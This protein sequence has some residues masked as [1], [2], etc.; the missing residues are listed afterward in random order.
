MVVFSP[1]VGSAVGAHMRAKGRKSTQ[2][3]RLLAS[4]VAVANR[5]GYARANVSA[6]IAEAGVSRPTFYDYFNDKDDCF[7]A[8]LRDVQELVAVRVDEVLAA[9]EPAEALAG[10][11]AA[12]ADLAAT[13]P[14]RARFLMSEAMAAGPAALQ[15]RDEGIEQLGRAVDD[16]VAAAAPEAQVPDVCP[17]SVIGGTYRL[18]ASRLRRGEPGIATLGVELE[19]WVASYAVAHREHRWRGL[20]AARGVVSGDWQEREPA[21]IG[22]PAADRPQSSEQVAEN[23]RQRILYAVA[24]LAKEKGYNATT[25]ADIARVA[26]VDAR[27][28]YALYSDKQDAFM[29]VHELGVQQVMSATAEGFFTGTSWAERVWTGGLAFTVF[30]QCN[31]LITQVGFVEA[32]A[33]G[34]RAVQRV[35]DSHVTFTIFL[36]EGYQHDAAT[37][38]PSRLALEAI[39]TTVF[40][41]VYRRARKQGQ[42]QTSGMP[43]QIAFLSLAP[44]AGPAEANAFIGTQLAAVA[45]HR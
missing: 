31:P 11:L 34:P 12:L 40:E 19:A 30:L 25:V 38:G 43:A 33:V 45:E 9:R 21:P 42:L 23:Q 3:E 10:T 15:A 29:S 27:G 17:R 41:I 1:I 18:L 13:A 26:G 39:V 44:F 2:R 36:Q 35:E 24:A 7:L 8:S 5:D 32:Y 14:G 20:E 4:M 37:A 6:V 28:F 16:A 22:P